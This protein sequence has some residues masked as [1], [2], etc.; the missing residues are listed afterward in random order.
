MTT[1]LDRERNKMSHL[2]DL[3]PEDLPADTRVVITSEIALFRER[4]AQR[5][6]D[7]QANEM[8]R[9]ESQG[10]NNNLGY[11][12]QNQNQGLSQ[13]FGPRSVDPQSYNQPIGFVS[14]GVGMAPSSGS[15]VSNVSTKEM[16]VV[17][18]DERERT[19][20]E[21]AEAEAIAIFREVSLF[22]ELLFTYH[23][24]EVDHS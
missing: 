6:L 14:A 2:Q 15:R 7:K 13:G 21:N 18:D 20:L 16:E 1:A 12:P 3:V 23:R 22:N 5:E 9:R 8:R 10:R 11:R 19:R 24:A 17:D 4:D